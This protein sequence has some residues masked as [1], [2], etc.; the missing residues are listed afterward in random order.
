MRR[1]EGRSV[2]ACVIARN[3]QRLSTQAVLCN[4]HT[5]HVKTQSSFPY[6][7]ATGTRTRTP[8]HARTHT[9]PS[10]SRDLDSKSAAETVQSVDELQRQHT[11]LGMGA[12]TRLPRGVQMSG[13]TSALEETH[14]RAPSARGV[15]TNDEAGLARA[16]EQE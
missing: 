14:A 13:C 2:R 6:G 7:C 15:C 9:V 16:K 12:G 3:R 4:S 5:E 11:H 10:L 1:G 8:A